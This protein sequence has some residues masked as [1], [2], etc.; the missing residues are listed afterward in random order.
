MMLE[1]AVIGNFPQGGSSVARDYDDLINL[2]EESHLSLVGDLID[3]LLDVQAENSST[4]DEY[5]EIS[6]GNPDVLNLLQADG[7]Q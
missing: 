3:P 5:E 6:S 7:S 1:N 4:S 2:A